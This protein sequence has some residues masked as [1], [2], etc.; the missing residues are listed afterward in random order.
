MM[1]TDGYNMQIK[2][3]D[4]ESTYLLVLF[5]SI[6]QRVVECIIIM[7]RKTELSLF[8]DYYMYIYDMAYYLCA[9]LVTVIS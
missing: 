2:I 9:Q 3:T 1:H 5:T 6:R 8:N 7:L 4:S